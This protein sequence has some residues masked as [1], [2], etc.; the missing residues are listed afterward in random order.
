LGACGAL[1]FATSGAA[2]DAP[3]ADEPQAPGTVAVAPGEHYRA[4]SFFRF[5]FGGQ[6]RDD[7][8]TPLH[9]PELDL[10]TFDGGL[11]PDRRGGHGL[12]TNSLRLRSGNGN[13]WAFR[14]VDKDA[15]KALDPELRGSIAGNLYRDITTTSQHPAGALVVAPLLDAVGVPHATPKLFVM[16]DD[17]RLG[18]FRDFAGVLGMLEIHPGHGFEGSDKA[19]GTLELFERMD[20]RADERV[21]ERA[22]LRARLMDVFVGDWDRHWN[23]WRWFRIDENG[24]RVWRPVPRDRDE[25]F[26][27]FDGLLPSIG[28][29]YTKFLVS[30]H[31]DYPA[32]D[33]LTFGGR[34]I[35]RR[36]LV[37][38]DQADWRAVTSDVVARLTD[39]TIAAAVRH[40]P[41]EIYARDGARLEHTLRVRRDALPKASDAFYRL[42]A[43]DVD[44][45]GTVGADVATIRRT[46]DGGV[47][48]TLSVRDE[49]TGEAVGPPYFHRLFRAGETSEIRLYLLGGADRVLEEG[50]RSGPIRV[51]IVRGD[52]ALARK[53]AAAA[54]PQ[55]KPGG[56]PDAEAVADTSVDDTE[57]LTR[58]YE[59]FRDWGT[60]W[61]VYPQLS[62]DGTRGL[63]AG[64][65][66]ERTQFGF[67]REPFANQMNFA[68]AW[69]TGLSE[70]RLEYRL[71]LRTQSPFG[72]LAYLAYSG[73]DFANF[74]GIGNT[75]PRSAS[76]DSHNFYRV[77]QHRF[78]VRPLV[79]ATLVGP[80]RARAGFAFQHFSNTP[81]DPG[82]PASGA[83]GSG[84]FSI[85]NTEAGL[86]F[87]SRSGLLTRR[88]GLLADVSVRYYPPWLDNAS[89][90]TKLRGEAVALFGSPFASPVLVSLRVA[91]EKNWGTYPFF[92]AAS[93]GGIAVTSP[94]SL[95]GGGTGSGG[96]T[97]NL[98][99]GYDLNRFAGD[100]SVVGNLDVF[101]PIG[102]YSAIVPLRFGIHG[103]ADVGRVFV[104]G[105]TSHKWHPGAGG[106]IWLAVRA[107]GAGLGEYAIAMSVSVVQSNEGT[108]F[109]LTSAFNF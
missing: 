2:A 1:L 34:Y 75:T 68:A 58:K 7:W 47:E 63:V 92:E 80:L 55:A 52:P 10:E 83:Y 44:V 99:R 21:D 96:S 19:L 13:T 12:Q 49:H 82:S 22:Y 36:F 5:F 85:A 3:R 39:E 30:F 79:T 94:L 27:R 6:W 101:V 43:E 53:R 35:D 15:R 74:F 8:T 33:K 23:Q 73:M 91:G 103:I 62:Y 11:T 60:D 42:L 50:E 20:Q 56:T 28:E 17:P 54:S 59:W 69:S 70:P 109:Y 61:L 41:P 78:G 76:L 18:D 38:L 24:V 105:E 57:R 71:D 104:A 14:S 107:A 40:L 108:S 37:G 88:R 102:K 16:P 98:L 86:D 9:V 77:I 95:S 89:G 81:H 45:Y 65:R 51:R 97:G 26:S 46:R 106:G 48:L 87:D 93:I 32:I 67:G 31:E 25:A 100:A 29:Y 90:F 4:G 84:T 72:V 64:A 66:L